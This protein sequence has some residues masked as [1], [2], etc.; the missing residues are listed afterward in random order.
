MLAALTLAGIFTAGTVM[1]QSLTVAVEGAYPPFSFFDN[2][3]KLAG[4]DVDIANAL[5]VE[6]KLDCQIISQEWDGLIPGLNAKKFDAI[7][8]SMT[9]TDERRQVVDF[10]ESYYRSPVRFMGR[11]GESFEFE[12]GGLSGAIIGVQS[13]TVYENWLK[14]TY[15]KA[16][17][18]SYQSTEEHNADLVAGRVDLVITD[19]LSLLGDFLQSPEGEDYEFLGPEITEPQLVGEGQAIAVRKGDDELRGKLNA[20][21]DAIRANGVYAEINDKYFTI[22]IFGR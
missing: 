14:Q 11:K 16:D 22:D 13:G 20:A 2:D 3:G 12:P 9:I 5:C 17:L 8:A 1:A 10:T 15:P 4:L 19:A 21:I 7:V 18:R 6:A